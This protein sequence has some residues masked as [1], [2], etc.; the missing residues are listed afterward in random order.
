MFNLLM[1][2]VWVMFREVLSAEKLELSKFYYSLQEAY[3][4]RH[5]HI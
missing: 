4:Q 3:W 2:E 5:K 1:T